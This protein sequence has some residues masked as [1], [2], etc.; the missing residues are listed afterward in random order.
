[1]SSIPRIHV[2]VEE[3]D[4]PKLSFDLYIC[5]A[6]P[7]VHTHIRH[8][9]VYVFN[10]GEMKKAKEAGSLILCKKCRRGGLGI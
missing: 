1:M 2:M 8:K 10:E 3:N 6:A 9:Y 4:S 7:C 5:N